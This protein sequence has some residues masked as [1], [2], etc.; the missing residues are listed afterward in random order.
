MINITLPGKP[1]NQKRHKFG[2]GFVYDP[3][4][5]DKKMI[6]EGLQKYAP[7]LP[8]SGDIFIQLYFHL[9]Y[10]KKWLRTG[11]YAG[12]LKDNA[13]LWHTT[14]PDIDNIAK[15]YLDSMN[16]IIYND[17]RQIVWLTCI[18]IYSLEPKTEITIRER[19]EINTTELLQRE[20]SQYN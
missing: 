5:K 4:S 11:K 17:D 19:H 1:K 10:P 6:K 12:I 14:K 15:I 13:P 18:K 16:D 2:R 9:P 20:Q 8:L 3:S 7:K